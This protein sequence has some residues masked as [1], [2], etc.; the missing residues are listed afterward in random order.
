MFKVSNGVKKIMVLGLGLVLLAAACNK[1][2]PTTPPASQPPVDNTTTAPTNSVS[3]ID[4][5]ASGFSPANI[6]V[7]QGTTVTFKNMDTLPHRPSSDPHPTHT[8][9]PDFDSKQPVAAGGSYTYTFTKVGT[10][11]YHD[12]F[13]PSM[14]GSVVVTP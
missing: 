7:K 11:S 13:N 2:S 9:L 14:R 5:T 6:T 4:M 10:W 12:H 3:Q 8:D 1:T